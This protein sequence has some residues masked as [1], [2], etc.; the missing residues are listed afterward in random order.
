MASSFVDFTDVFRIL[1]DV[2]FLNENNIDSQNIILEKILDACANSIFI[3][4]K[5]TPKYSA[6]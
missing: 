4:K 1:A 5:D 6:I 3:N 2:E